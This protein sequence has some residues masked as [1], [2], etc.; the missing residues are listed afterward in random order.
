MD[1]GGGVRG[2]RVPPA[3]RGA[4]PLG[5]S[6]SSEETRRACSQGRPGRDCVSGCQCVSLAG[7]AG[8][9]LS[10]SPPPHR[11]SRHIALIFQ[12]RSLLF[13]DDYTFSPLK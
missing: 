4:D 9:L 12:S 11:L 3:W 2:V 10:G 7:M 5:K 6:T 1:L 13:T 8:R